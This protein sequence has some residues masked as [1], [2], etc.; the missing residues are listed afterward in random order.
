[1]EVHICIL[2][3]GRRDSESVELSREQ[4]RGVA[5]CGL[6]FAMY[7][8]PASHFKVHGVDPHIE[9]SLFFRRSRERLL[10]QPIGELAHV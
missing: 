7:L 9:K 6:N 10:G 2:A 1:M 3:P 4:I 5:G 8:L